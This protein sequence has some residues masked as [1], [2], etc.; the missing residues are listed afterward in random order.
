MAVDAELLQIFRDETNERL[1]RI[2]TSLLALE[3]GDAADDALD[4]LFRDAH[5]IKGNAGMV[6]FAEAQQIAHAIEDM[7]EGA[8]ASG[9]LAPALAAPLL[10]ATDAIRKVI[11]GDTGLAGEAL[12][13]LQAASTAAREQPVC[14]PAHAANGAP[15]PP[16]ARAAQH[17]TSANGSPGAL[18]DQRSMRVGAAKVDRLLD[19]VGETVLHRRRLDHLIG[20]RVS[21]S[22]QAVEDE[23]AGGDRLL[24]DLR[25]A[26]ISMR[27]LPLSSIAGR[28]PRA[29]RDLALA[30]GKQVHLEMIGAETQLDRVILDGISESIVH[31]LR[32]SI[33]HGIETLDERNR[34]GKPTSAR[35]ELRAEPRGDQVAV[36]VA[37]DGR[38]V[39]EE[40]LRRGEASGSL[41]EVLAEAGLSTAPEVT[42]LSGRGVG[43]DAVKRHV[44]SLGGS[45]VASSRPG[46]GTEMTMLLPLTTSLLNLLLVER[47]GHVFGLPLGSVS[48]VVRV[49]HELSLKGQRSV[50]LRGAAVALAD[51]ADVL[52]A[53]APAA[54]ATPVALVVSASGRRVAVICDRVIGEEEAVVKTLGPLLRGVPGYLGAAVLPDGRIALILDPSFVCAQPSRERVPSKTSNNGN[55]AHRVLVVDDEFTVRELQRSILEAAGYDVLTARNGRE[56]LD[57]L[58]GKTP[59]ELVVTDIEMPEMDGLELL[60]AIR[61][62]EHGRSLPAI[63]VTSRGS[64]EDR[65]RGADAGADA[66]IV[67]ADFDQEGLLAAVSRLLEAP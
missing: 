67:K 13:A 11:D 43:L 24:D 19:V 42:E 55:H 61:S 56:A 17:D 46:H 41:A 26:V 25:D 12:R 18:E 48:E 64:E 36:T 60:G 30:E 51:L 20:G 9:G 50:E 7:L 44:E 3:S 8:R 35:V 2:V 21:R 40:L 47:G 58:A 54:S 63:V 6:G 27:T 53:V 37:D 28:F 29:V 1:D 59:V 14:S 57:A 4:S 22:D 31:L 45:L 66:Y 62:R 65:Q 15:S 34:A 38:G 52:G 39:S 33:S 23:L 32:N 5:S 49:S 16:R 10:S